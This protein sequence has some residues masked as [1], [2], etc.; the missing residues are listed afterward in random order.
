MAD[1]VHVI[2]RDGLD[3]EYAKLFKRP[4][5]IQFENGKIEQFD[6]EEEAC[7]FQRDYRWH[8]GLDIHTGEPRQEIESLTD[9]ILRWLQGKI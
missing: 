2:E 4:W 3:I 9:Y 5:L 7:A 8:H 1:D 6:T